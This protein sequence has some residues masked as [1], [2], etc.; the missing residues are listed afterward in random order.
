MLCCQTMRLVGVL[1]I[2]GFIGI[3][4]RLMSNNDY[5]EWE[6]QESGS[7]SRPTG[8]GVSAGMDVLTRRGKIGEG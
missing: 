7:C 1:V 5:C 4:Y 6:V 2:C 3:S 8:L